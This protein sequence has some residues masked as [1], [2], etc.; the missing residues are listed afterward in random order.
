MKPDRKSG[1]KTWCKHASGRSP[2]SGRSELL[3]AET[4]SGDPTPPVLTP[5]PFAIIRINSVIIIV[6]GVSGPG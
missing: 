4:S 1:R 3:P 5:K 6:V 2:L